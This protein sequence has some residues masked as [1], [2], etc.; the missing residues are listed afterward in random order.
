MSVCSGIYLEKHD[1]VEA[2]GVAHGFDH[3]G[4]G[5]LHTKLF[6]MHLTKTFEVETLYYYSLY[7]AT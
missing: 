4:L 2:P 1:V 3:E 7:C 5:Q 6:C